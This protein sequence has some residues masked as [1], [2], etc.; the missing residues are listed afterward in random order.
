MTEDEL[1]AIEARLA[2]ATEWPWLKHENGHG[3]HWVQSTTAEYPYVCSQEPREKNVKD[4]EF[5]AHAPEDTDT[6][7]REVRRL[8]A[9]IAEVAGFEDDGREDYLWLGSLEALAKE[10]REV[11]VAGEGG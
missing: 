7:C 10:A 9:F 3:F 5:I 2:A 4:L 11:L 8:R 6:L 1:A